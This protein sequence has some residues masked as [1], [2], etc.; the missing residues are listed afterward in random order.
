[1][2]AYRIPA[3][4]ELE[5]PAPATRRILPWAFIATTALHAGVLGTAFAV[6]ATEP[7]APQTAVVTVLNGHVAE[8]GFQVGGVQQA[9]V[10][11]P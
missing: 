1:M 6:R 11:L 4:D 7:V 2:S 5:A 3:N 10:R 8:A 9:R